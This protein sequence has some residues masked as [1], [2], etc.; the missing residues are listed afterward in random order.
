MIQAGKSCFAR[1]RHADILMSK[2]SAKRN[3]TALKPAFV[4]ARMKHKAIV[5]GSATDT[6]K[7]DWFCMMKTVAF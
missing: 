1:E 3:G 6:V 2:R 4:Y 7:G 5:F